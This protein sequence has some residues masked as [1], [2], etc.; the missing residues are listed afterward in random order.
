VF[1]GLIEQV[2]RVRQLRQGGTQVRLTVDCSF[3][4]E[5]IRLGD[6]IAVNGSCLTVVEFASGWFSADL[7]P[8]TLQ[9]TSLHQLAAGSPVNLERALKLSD[10]LGGHLVSGH[11]DTV[12]TVLRREQDRNAVC[13]QIGVEPQWLRYLV[14]KG[15]VAIDGISLTVNSVDAAGFSVTVIPHTLAQTTLVQCRSG[16]RVNIET[17]LLGKYVERLLTG[18]ERVG[19]EGGVTLESLAKHGFL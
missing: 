9:R 14:E 6:S 4:V 7:S 18:R 15:S 1:T 5:E 2:G 13:F 10:R 19:S 8:E 12:G 16:S 11:V 17:D 3:P